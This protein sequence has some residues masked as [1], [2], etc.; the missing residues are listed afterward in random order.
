[1][2]RRRIH[3]SIDFVC[4]VWI[5]V[6]V[7]FMCPLPCASHLVMHH[8]I[9]DTLW[10]HIVHW[11]WLWMA[12]LV[13]HC[14]GLKSS[15]IVMGRWKLL[16]LLILWSMRTRMTPFPVGHCCRFTISVLPQILPESFQTVVCIR[17]FRKVPWSL[18]FPGCGRNCAAKKIEL[19][20]SHGRGLV[21]EN[22]TEDAVLL[23]LPEVTSFRDSGS[24]LIGRSFKTQEI[25]Q[26]GLRRIAGRSPKF[27]WMNVSNEGHCTPCSDGKVKRWKFSFHAVLLRAQK[28]DAYQSLLYWWRQ[29]LIHLIVFGWLCHI[30]SWSK[31]PNQ[32][33]HQYNTFSC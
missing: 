9:V 21:A 4:I 19:L 5:H 12:I 2:I 16:L 11:I 25:W 30:I 22:P 1:M 33:K 6:V 14:F 31:K 8:H 13:I 18:Y 15:W 7:A 3:W 20:W 32:R 29:N 27:Q 24:R 10:V 17:H 23:F 28:W 26:Y